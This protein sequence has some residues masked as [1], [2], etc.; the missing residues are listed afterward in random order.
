MA[1]LR[2]YEDKSD[3]TGEDR[4]VLGGCAT[5]AGWGHRYGTGRQLVQGRVQVQ[6]REAGLLHRP[7][8]HLP[9]EEQVAGGWSTVPALA[10]TT[11][12]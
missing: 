4:T 12:Q 1:E 7:L 9:G 6:Q 8:G 3:A 11:G 2:A 5:V 10:W